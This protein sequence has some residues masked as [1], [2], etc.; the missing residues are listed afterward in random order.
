VERSGKATVRWDPIACPQSCAD[1]RRCAGHV[2]RVETEQAGLVWQRD[3]DGVWRAALGP[4]RG[5]YRLTCSAPAGHPGPAPALDWDA[6]PEPLRAV[7]ARLE[8]PAG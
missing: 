4:P 2:I 8:P 3:Q 6:L 7:L 1:G 5:R